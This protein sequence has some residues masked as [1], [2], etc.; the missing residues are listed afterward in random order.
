MGSREGR[1]VRPWT[2]AIDRSGGLARPG[3]DR[4]VPT[5]RVHVRRADH[6][7]R[8]A[9]LARA[10]LRRAGRLPRWHQ[11]EAY[12]D[13]TK[14]YRALGCWIPLDPATADSG[15]MTFLPGSHLGEV[16]PHRHLDDDPEV[17]G[18]VV[19]DLEA[20]DESTAVAV[21]L[22]PGGATFHHCRTLHRTPPNVSDRVPRA[23]ATELQTEPIPVSAENAADRPWVRAGM[24]AWEQRA[25]YRS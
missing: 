12:W 17:H 2:A 21:P 13:E 22:A 18:L 25:V 1:R 5:R 11:D 20:M 15:C 3:A 19:R 7:R 16:P 14:Q 24:E 8:R 4:A 10:D 6:H 23:W 9:R